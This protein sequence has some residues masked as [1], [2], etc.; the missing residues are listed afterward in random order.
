MFLSP[1]ASI[2]KVED[3]YL[4]QEMPLQM[5]GVLVTPSILAELEQISLSASESLSSPD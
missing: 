2:P 3:F 4:G 1:S 5:K